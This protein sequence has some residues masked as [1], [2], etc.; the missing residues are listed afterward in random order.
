MRARPPRVLRTSPGPDAV[1]PGISAIAAFFNEPIDT[2]TLT[3]ATFSGGGPGVTFARVGAA[4][5]DER[6]TAFRTAAAPKAGRD[7]AE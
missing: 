7:A 6:R 2:S 3:P 4:D 1:V 5:W